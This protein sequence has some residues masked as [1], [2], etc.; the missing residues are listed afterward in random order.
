MTHV[1]HLQEGIHVQRLR[2]SY[3]E[4]HPQHVAAGKV[5]VHVAQNAQPHRSLLS[6]P[7]LGQ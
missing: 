4:I 6:Q 2:Q 3:R 7:V 1:A 5:A